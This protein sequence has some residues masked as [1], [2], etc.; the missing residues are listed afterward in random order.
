MITLTTR[1]TTTDDTTIS[2]PTDN[3]TVSGGADDTTILGT[4]DSTGSGGRRLVSVTPADL[5]KHRSTAIALIDVDNIVIGRDGRIDPDSAMRKLA[6]VYARLSTAELSLAVMSAS[7]NEALGHEPWF[8]FP[9][10]TWQVAE[11]GPD[12]AD[13]QLLDFVHAALKQRLGSRVAVAS[14]DGIFAVLAEVAELEVVV[15][16]E[17]HG[18]S[19]RLRPYLCVRGS[20]V[21]PA[22]ALVQMTGDIAEAA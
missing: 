13:H 3:T 19:D 5:P 21:R 1:S 14:G 4:T 7:C 17:H 11:V 15:P 18:V 10:W 12:A 16:V 22:S 2:G 9:K 20:R 8:R 6:E